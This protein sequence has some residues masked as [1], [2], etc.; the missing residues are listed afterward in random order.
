MPLRCPLAIGRLDPLERMLIARFASAFCS[1]ATFGV[2]QDGRQSAR[3]SLGSRE[4]SL[5]RLSGHQVMAR[6]AEGQK[7]AQAEDVPL[8]L[9]ALLEQGA[10]QHL[11][12]A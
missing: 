1:E 4:V 10:G 2:D 8:T 11:R 7:L 5:T 3:F 9:V 6:D 12:V